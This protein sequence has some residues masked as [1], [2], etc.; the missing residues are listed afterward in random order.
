VASIS[1]VGSVSLRRDYL[2]TILLAGG[3]AGFLD[4]V[5]ASAAKVASGGTPLQPWKSVAGALIGKDAVVA[6][7]DPVALL[8]MALH[9]LITT[10][11]A[12]IYVLVALRF[13]APIR[14]PVTSGVIFGILFL[15]AMNYLILPLSKIGHPLYTGVGGLILAAE[16][17]ILM[18][19]LPISLIVAWRSRSS[20]A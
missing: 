6:A 3:T 13:H 4:F 8:G 18:I 16:N 2:S 15:L 12:A 10:T 5:A 14:R 7:G 11:A 17:H 9:F 19:G 20:A 1:S